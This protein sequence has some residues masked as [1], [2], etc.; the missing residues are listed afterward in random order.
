MPGT[1]QTDNIS[2]E[3]EEKQKGKET[4]ASKNQ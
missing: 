3:K 1:T 4:N 2:Q